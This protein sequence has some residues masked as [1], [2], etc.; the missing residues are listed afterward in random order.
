M[1]SELKFTCATSGLPGGGALVKVEPTAE[2]FTKLGRALFKL[3]EYDRSINAY[4]RAVKLD[5][6]YW[7]AHNG[8]GVNALNAWLGSDKQDETKWREARAS[9]RRSLQANNDQQQVIIL[10]Q[11]YGLL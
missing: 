2:S 5:P 6:K 7:Q 3:G 4:R 11:K 10:M 8:V 9:F 1:V